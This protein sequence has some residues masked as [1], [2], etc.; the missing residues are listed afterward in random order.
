L[1]LLF[2]DSAPLLPLLLFA[3]E[4]LY[5]DLFLNFPLPL[6]RLFAGAFFAP[7]LDE[8]AATAVFGVVRVFFLDADATDAVFVEVDDFL[9]GW[10]LPSSI[11]AL[12]I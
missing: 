8:A 6:L 12:L 7:P 9:D 10:R 5:V 2:D 4:R 1:L 11:D 3:E